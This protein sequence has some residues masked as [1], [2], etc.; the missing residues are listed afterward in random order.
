MYTASAA[1]NRV[2]YSRAKVRERSF[3]DARETRDFAALGL[4]ERHCAEGIS[5]TDS[6]I[7]VIS[8][9]RIIEK[10]NGN[11]FINSFGLVSYKN[12]CPGVFWNCR[13]GLLIETLKILLRGD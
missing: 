5:D 10:S 6:V 9:P 13:T 11:C 8:L 12:Q 7:S 4:D 1:R 3:S 2:I